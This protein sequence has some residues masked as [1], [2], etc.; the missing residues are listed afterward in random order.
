MIGSVHLP[1]PNRREIRAADENELRKLLA[2]DLGVSLDRLFLTHGATEANAAI[3]QYLARVRPGSNRT[4]RVQLPEYPDLFEAARWAGFP[5]TER[6]SPAYVAVL[7]QPRNPEGHLW[8]TRHLLEWAEGVRHVLV[9]ET[10]REFAKSP[11]V[12]SVRPKGVWVTGT[13]TKFYGGDELRVGFLVA[14]EEEAAGFDHYHALVFDRLAGYSVAGA[15][16]ALAAREQLRRE[17][18][19]VL[20]VNRAAWQEAFP[21][22]A[23]PAAPVAFDRALRET[24]QSLAERCLAASV[25]VCPGGLFGDGRGVRLCLTRRSFP[26]D[27]GRYLAVRDRTPA[28]IPNR[29][30]RMPSRRARPRR[31][32]IDRGRDGP[33]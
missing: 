13:F 31:A 30:K 25:L 18:D 10:F 1:L 20:S 8:T 2:E 4:C 32:G 19:R 26:H 7:S 3:L 14:P 17:V 12:H 15:L 29:T 28:L 16:K 24:G 27:L 6:R 22:Q 33:A 23:P 5:P 11:S 9:D 21:G